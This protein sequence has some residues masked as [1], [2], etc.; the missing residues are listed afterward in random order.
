MQ[1][2]Y[3]LIVLLALPML[4]F[5]QSPFTITENNFPFYGVQLYERIASPTGI[6]LIPG[7]N[8]N[9]DFSAFHSTDT[10]QNVYFEETDP[11][12]TNAG[13]DVYIRDFK[14]LNSN[15]GYLLFYEFDFNS[16]G[17]QEKG[18][19]VDPQAYALTAFTGN[20]LDSLKFPLQ[21]A[22]YPSGIQTMQFPATYQSDW[23]SQS[24][25]VV[26]FT[27]SV[28]AAGL[29]NTPCQHIYTIFRTDNLVGWGKMRVYSG[30][31]S[32]IPYDVLI[33][34]VSE[35]AV[36]SF[37]VNG[38]PAPPVLTAAFGITQGQQTD[39]NKNYVVYREGYSTPLAIFSYG[40]NNYITPGALFF[41]VENLT[42]ITGVT[43][44]EQPAYSTLLFPNPSSTGE[45]VLQVFGEA[46][47]VSTYRILDL[48][49]RMVQSGTA[50]LATGRLHVQ[51]NDELPNGNYVLQV[52]SDRKQTTM[53]EQ[54]V[55]AR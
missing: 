45:L 41:D 24:R 3:T 38:S 10:L 43:G 48:Q 33:N 34:R 15:L 55:L 2:N 35:Y 19:Y 42:T 1:K 46:P 16:T 40:A 9:W 30:G 26:N 11:F 44:P 7:A 37:F 29:N 36:D 8:G 27:L 32:S 20:P 49:G 21:T 14:A 39:V 5:S 53:N 28:Q 31:G 23:Q 12:Y 17:V 13:I 18:I 6:N 4:A 54:F 52:L 25:R 22:V 47:P 51:L 50:D